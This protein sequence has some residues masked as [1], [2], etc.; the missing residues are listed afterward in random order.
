MRLPRTHAQIETTQNFGDGWT[1]HLIRVGI[2]SEREHRFKGKTQFEFEPVAP[3][4]ELFRGK[5]H[6]A[7]LT[8]AVEQMENKLAELRESY[9]A[10]DT[11]DKR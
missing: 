2:W 11:G 4:G 3:N 7:S 1:A 9:L 8:R 10:R 5:T 6:T